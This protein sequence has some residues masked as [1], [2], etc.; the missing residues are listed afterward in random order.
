MKALIGVSAVLTVAMN[1]P[2]AASQRAGSYQSVQ[3]SPAF[4]RVAQTAGVELPA[5]RVAGAAGNPIALDLKTQ[6]SG[7]RFIRIS[8]FPEDLQL[9]RGFRLRG[10]WI[11]SVQDLENVELITRPASSRH[12]SSM[13]RISA[14]TKLRR[15][16]SVC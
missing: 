6:T 15:W 1:P 14:A 8:D 13:W 3:S 10:A 9:S 11:T 2:C 16:P 5:V 7:V 12:S 4:V